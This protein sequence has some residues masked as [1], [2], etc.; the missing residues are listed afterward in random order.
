MSKE[1]PNNFLWLRTNTLFHGRLVSYFILPSARQ[2]HTLNPSTFY[3]WASTNVNRISTMYY[4]IRHGNKWLENTYNSR[5]ITVKMHLTCIQPLPNWW[6]DWSE[7]SLMNTLRQVI[8]SI[9]YKKIEKSYFITVIGFN[10][11]IEIC[12]VPRKWMK[13]EFGL[14]T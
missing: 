11:E 9:D 13:T 14:L 1:L 2:W 10:F 6:C 3:Y 4:E 12:T 8:P 5:V 7:W